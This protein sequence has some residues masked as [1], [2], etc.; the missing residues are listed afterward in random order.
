MPFSERTW[1]RVLSAERLR[2]ALLIGGKIQ[3]DMVPS[4]LLGWVETLNEGIPLN[5]Q[6]T[7]QNP[8]H[9]ACTPLFHDILRDHRLRHDENQRRRLQ[10]FI[11][12][13]AEL[14]EGEIYNHYHHNENE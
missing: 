3:C 1:H 14:R 7:S 13:D 4:I 12:A 6:N 8:Q 11:I 9:K 5:Y 2:R 10:E